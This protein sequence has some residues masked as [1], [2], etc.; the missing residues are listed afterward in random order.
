MRFAVPS[1]RQALPVVV[2]LAIVAFVASRLWG[3]LASVDLRHV[4]A[5][6]AAIPGSQV[7]VAALLVGVL[8]ATLATYEAIAARFVAGPVGTGRAVLTALIASPIGHAI[9]FG[10]LSGGAV[11][12][13]L[14]TAVGMRPLDV[15]K[16][17]VLIALP[18]AAGLGLLLGLALVVRSDEAALVL[19]VDP[20][21]ARSSG[22]ALL[23]LH[24]LY[25]GLVLRRRGPVRV[26]RVTV[27]LPPPPMT[28]VQYVI[29]AIE[30]C[31]GAG[32]LYAL[33]PETANL[34]YLMFVGVYVLGVLVGLASSVPAG[35]GVLEFVLLLFIKGVPREQ[36]L[37]AVLGYRFLLELVPLGASLLLFAGY[38]A[39]SR[40][41][42][43]RARLARLRDAA[44][45]AERDPPPRPR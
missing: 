12:Y 45:R 44:R 11:R 20:G 41:P 28:A 8:F 5:E 21:L 7:A 13:R 19:K 30:V 36:L 24:A 38:E 27:S 6:V 9:G 35:L 37:G 1:P 31:T 17:V 43:P 3:M 33:L 39:W 4:L 2:S 15:G 18:Y 42:G 22:L 10:A 25:V 16:M 26:G 34:T 40:L 14:Y 29:G 23:A 32:V